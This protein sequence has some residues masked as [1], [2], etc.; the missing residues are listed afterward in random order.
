M[1]VEKNIIVY[2]CEHHLLPI[3]RAHAYISNGTVI[4]FQNE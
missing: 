4:G 3:I 2:S 1:L